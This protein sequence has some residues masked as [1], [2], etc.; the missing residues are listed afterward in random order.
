MN[1]DITEGAFTWH[2]GSDDVDSSLHPMPIPV[3]EGDRREVRAEHLGRKSRDAIEA[4]LRPGVED[5]HR[6]ERRLA[7]LLV[8]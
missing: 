6:I 7:C 2:F 5:A 3:D 1:R 4:L 8:G